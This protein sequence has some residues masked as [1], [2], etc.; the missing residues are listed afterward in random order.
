MRPSRPTHRP[1]VRRLAR[2]T[3]GGLLLTSV[4]TGASLPAAAQTDPFDPGAD[5]SEESTS[6]APLLLQYGWWNKG[7][8]S[9]A[10]GQ[11]TPAP[12]GA[13][14]DGLFVLYGPTGV[15]PPPAVT[16][17]LGAVPP[18][19]DPVDV[20]PLGPEAFGAVRYSVPPGAEAVL[21]LRYTPTS[22]TQPGGTNPDVGDI[23]ACPV[24]STWDPVQNGRYDSAPVYDCAT[25][26]R[27][28]VAG[29]AVDFILPAALGVDGVFDLAI[30]PAGTRPYRVAFQPPT[31]A[32]LVLTSIPESAAEEEFDLGSFEDPALFEDPA[33]DDGSTTFGAED[34]GTSFD[35][36][37]A[38]DFSAGTFDTTTVPTGSV[39]PTRPVPPR[40][41]AVPTAIANPLAA[42][43]SRGE[44]IMAVALLALLAAGLWWI[45][46]QQVRAPRLLGS[47]GAGQP[48]VPAS[49]VNARGIGRFSRPRPS[50]KPRR[51]F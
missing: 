10:G 35:D 6:S 25:G 31:S 44:R 45:G 2:I 28:T 34:F 16:G 37:S 15:A 38:G 48:V 5:A 22:S 36:L 19:P 11:P 7:Q 41:V 42:D 20:R 13:P 17:P 32:S 4:A 3:A 30:V 50:E 51:L 21:T 9:P 24:S 43:A 23:F 8:Q 26:A 40:Q 14:A 12:P 39:A 46:G 18:P 27:G 47:L 29:D 49:E 1:L 33:F